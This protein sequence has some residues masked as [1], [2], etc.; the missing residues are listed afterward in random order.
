M[1]SV[2]SLDDHRQAFQSFGRDG[3]LLCHPCF[4]S[5]HTHSKSVTWRYQAWFRC[6]VIVFVF[7]QHRNCS[8]FCLRVVAAFWTIYRVFQRLW[9]PPL[10]RFAAFLTIYS[11][12]FTVFFLLLGTVY[13]QRWRFIMDR[14]QRRDVIRPIPSPNLKSL[15]SFEHK[16]WVPVQIFPPLS[17]WRCP[18][19][20]SVDSG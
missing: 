14:V 16:Y 20:L 2:T 4:Y 15:L 12:L 9:S 8:R 5:T 3:L 18:K 11:P 17:G 1:S 13:E 7:P 19:R 10:S 6:M